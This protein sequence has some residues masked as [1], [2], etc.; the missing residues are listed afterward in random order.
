[1]SKKTKKRPEKEYFAGEFGPVTDHGVNFKPISPSE[2]L[3]Y[4]R[5]R[6]IRRWLITETCRNCPDHFRLRRSVDS[7]QSLLKDMLSARCPI[8]LEDSL[9]FFIQDLGPA[10]DD[11][12]CVSLNGEEWK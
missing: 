10:E 8:C 3:R 1:M 2:L 4:M 11:E 9:E 5:D 6:Q 12:P 7:K